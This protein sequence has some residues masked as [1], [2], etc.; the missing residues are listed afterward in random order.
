MYAVVGC[1]EC[2]A[3]WLLN[4]PSAS[5]TARCPRCGRTHQTKKLKRFFQSSARDAAREAR[6]ALLAKKH[7]DSEAFAAV[8]HTAV[9]EQAVEDAG[10]DDREYLE[11]S[12]ID[13]D[14]VFEAGKRVNTGASGSSS[15]TAVIRDAIHEC[16]EPTADRIIAYAAKHDVET[17]DTRKILK[18][19]TQRGEVTESRGKYRIL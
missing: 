2:A 8:E 7:G 10:I 3:M 5:T 14:A 15:P 12:G 6:A 1:T 19:M 18:K 17:S 11:A 9:L 13:A 16:E 4:D